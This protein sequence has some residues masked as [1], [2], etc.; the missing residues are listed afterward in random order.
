MVDNIQ[1]LGRITICMVTEYILG[2]TGGAMRDTT[3]SIKSMA[4]GS[5]NGPTGGDMKATGI[6]ASSMARGSTYYL[7][8]LSRLVFGKMGK[9]PIGLMN[10]YIFN[11]Y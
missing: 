10:D 7:T 1:G 4:M 11:T 8:V 5:T 3:S 6:M 9:G 2:R